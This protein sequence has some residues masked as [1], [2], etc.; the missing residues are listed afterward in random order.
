MSSAEASSGAARAALDSIWGLQRWQRESNRKPLTQQR[1]R[2]INSVVFPYLQENDEYTHKHEGS[3]D[4]NLSLA[5]MLENVLFLALYRKHPEEY[6]DFRNVRYLVE[7]VE[8]QFETRSLVLEG[9]ELS[10]ETT[11]DVDKALLE[12][13]LSRGRAERDATPTRES[14]SRRYHLETAILPLVRRE[15]RGTWSDEERLHVAAYIDRV[16]YLAFAMNDGSYY[17]PRWI[18]FVLK[19]VTAENLEEGREIEGRRRERQD[20]RRVRRR[21]AP[22]ISEVA[23]LYESTTAEIRRSRW[24]RPDTNRREMMRETI[25][26]LL[27]RE[28]SPEESQ[29]LAYFADNL[30]YLALGP[31]LPKYENLTE[32]VQLLKGLP[33]LQDVLLEGSELKMMD[34]ASHPAPAVSQAVAAAA[35]RAELPEVL[36]TQMSTDALIFVSSRDGDPQM[37]ELYLRARRETFRLLRILNHTMPTATRISL[38][39]AKANIGNPKQHAIMAVTGGRPGEGEAESLTVHGY[40]SAEYDETQTLICI[41]SIESFTR[42][43]SVAERL[44]V[45]LERRGWPRELH[46]EQVPV[47][48]VRDITSDGMLFWRRMQERHPSWDISER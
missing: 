10:V 36:V 5:H 40:V 37:R 2:M 46:P 1:L 31:E 7:K 28:F 8:R 45:E 41:K 34:E 29:R 13:V 39:Y 9:R 24:L 3:A 6:S 44:V 48:Y 33:S 22:L 43:Q 18:S 23:E 15:G 16:L 17:D 42:R 19:R 26:P 21:T 25:V 32:T 20:D 14:G 11:D 38:S 35:A 4:H 47:I 12:A 27:S 30:L